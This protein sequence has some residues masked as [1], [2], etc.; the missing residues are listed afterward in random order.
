MSSLCQAAD[1][2]AKLKGKNM[3]AEPQKPIPPTSQD[4]RAGKQASIANALPT[5]DKRFIREISQRPAES[6]SRGIDEVSV[7]SADEAEDIISNRDADYDE[8]ESLP[9]AS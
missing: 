5:D 8:G 3:V 2:K 1:N 4:N 6:S 7:E 9:D